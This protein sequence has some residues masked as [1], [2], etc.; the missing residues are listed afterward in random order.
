MGLDISIEKELKMAQFENSEYY[1]NALD[2]L[3][4]LYNQQGELTAFSC[5]ERE[6]G[7]LADL[8]Q[9]EFKIIDL[10]LFLTLKQSLNQ[11]KKRDC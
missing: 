9:S 1:L 11:V 10:E 2:S 7:K 8:D 3:I 5:K 6:E 4:S